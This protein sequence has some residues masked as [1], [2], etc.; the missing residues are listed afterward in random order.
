[1]RGYL[2]LVRWC[3]R[4]RVAD[5]AR[6]AASSSSARCAACRCCRPASSRPTTCRRRRSAVAL[7]PGSTFAQ[8]DGDW[9]SRRAQIVAEEPVRQ[10]DL[11]DGRRRRVPAATRSCRR[12]RAEVRK[13]TLTLN[14]TPRGERGGAASRRSS[15]SCASA[16]VDAA[17][18]AH[19][20]RLRRL[21]EKYML[22]LAGEDGAVLADAARARRAGAAHAPRHRQR[23]LDR[24]ACCGPS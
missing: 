14:L 17:G 6:R 10:A 12:W 9:P 11:H 18:R 16:L 23:H 21:G 1:M 5:D 2:R 15:A 3:L 22:V 4:H 8:T 7:P 13:A 20:R 24:R 19:Q